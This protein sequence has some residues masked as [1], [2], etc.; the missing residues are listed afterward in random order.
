MWAGTLN[1]GVSVWN[2][3]EWKNYGVLDGPLGE[4]VFDIA[5]CPRDGDMWIATNAG[6]TRYSQQKD[7]WSY[8]T[9]AD[10]LPSDPIQAIAFDKNGDMLLGT[11]CDGVAMAR[12]ADG[13]KTWRV[14]SGPQEMPVTATGRGLPTS[15]INDVLVANDG[16][17]Y[18]ATTTGLAWSSDGGATWSYTRGQDYADK[19][20]GLYGGAPQ[21]WKEG[22]G[23]VLAEDY[24]SCLAQDEAGRLWLGHWKQGS[25]RV[26]MQNSLAGLRIKE[27]SNRQKSGLVRD[28]LPRAQGGLLLARHDQG[29]SYGALTTQSHAAV[30]QAVGKGAPP[31]LPTA[32]QAPTLN[33]LNALL[34]SLGEIKPLDPTQTVVTALADDWTTQGDWLG[35]YGRYWASLNA[36]VS[37]SNYYWGGGWTQIDHRFQID[38][39]QKNDALRYWVHWLYTDNTRSLE[40][41]PTY[42]DSRLQ[43]GLTTRDSYRR[44]AELD[45]HGEAYPMTKEGPH[46]YLSVDVPSGLWN[47]SF[48]NFNANGENATNWRR[49]YRLSLRAQPSKTPLGQVDDFADWPELAHG[50]FR[51]FRGGVY[52]RFLVRGPQRLTVKMDRNNSYNTIWAGAFLD[53][54]DEKPAP[55]FGTVDEWKKRQS[56]RQQKRDELSAQTAE[57]R[58]ARFAPAKNLDEAVN[59][60]FIEIERLRD[61]NPLQWSQ[62]NRSVYQALA[63]ATSPALTEGKDRFNTLTDNQ[64]QVLNQ[65]GGSFYNLTLYNSWEELQR[66]LGLF[67]ARDVEKAL[68]WDGLSSG[69][70]GFQ[71]ISGHLSSLPPGPR[72]SARSSN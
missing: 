25:E 41:P 63:R 7:S 61:S 50:R 67:P 6:L 15:L 16:T 23:A 32:A 28:I 42:L 60:L 44:Q 58:A 21:G 29:L 9:R 51:E 59:R 1:H 26:E 39:R 24:V 69:G 14:V 46:I 66:Q 54:V 57:E 71:V 40:M 8:L 35:R 10:G 4:R 13:Y 45:D 30:S 56:E 62:R 65:R 64:K 49:D 27:V 33:E 3:R 43:K 19:V 48:Y 22:R 47:L 52:K 68:R 36:M 31:A 18:A 55:Y 53:M 72:L 34:A 11:P 38:P 17:F 70:E 37:P 20:R 2:G 12:A 5:V